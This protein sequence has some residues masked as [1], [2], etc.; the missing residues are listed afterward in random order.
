MVETLG[1]VVT[2]WDDPCERAKALR[3]AYFD[4][5]AGGT[6]Q[7]VRFRHGD[8]EQEVQTSTLQGSLNALRQEMQ[9]AEDEC[10]AS[11]GL[12]PINRRFAIVGGSRRR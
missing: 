6:A 8:N 4:R 12:P 5:L 10:R 11:Q 7:R 9:N 3:D 2:N 1:P